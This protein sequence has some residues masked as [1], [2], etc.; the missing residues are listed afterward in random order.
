[1]QA[2]VQLFNINDEV[3]WT[4]DDCQEIRSCTPTP[5]YIHRSTFRQIRGLDLETESEGHWENRQNE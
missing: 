1:M 3:G 2:I 5:D 4:Y